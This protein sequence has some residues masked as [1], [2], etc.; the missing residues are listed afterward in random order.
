MVKVKMLGV[1]TIAPFWKEKIGGIRV[2][3]YR[4]AI[5]ALSDRLLEVLP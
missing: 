5:S 2:I 1:P 3:S 4:C